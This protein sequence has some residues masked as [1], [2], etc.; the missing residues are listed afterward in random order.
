MG[1]FFI[2]IVKGTCPEIHNCNCIGDNKSKHGV[3]LRCSR[4]ESIQE[5][6]FQKYVSS[7]NINQL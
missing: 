5:L 1:F 7:I 2:R 3:K 4:V 6:S